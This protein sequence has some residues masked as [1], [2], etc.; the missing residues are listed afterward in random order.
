VQIIC[1]GDEWFPSYRKGVDFVQKYIFPGGML[2]SPT[3]LRQQ[4]AR[5]GLDFTGS[6]E[7]GQSYSD[8]LRQ[9]RDVFNA[10]WPEIEKLG[11]DERF[12]RMWNFYLTSCA[13]TFLAGTTDVTQIAIRRPA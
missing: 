13:G 7:F 10:R 9:W 5:A 1:I 8:T 3:A 4:V 11:F 6:V 12:H 2:P